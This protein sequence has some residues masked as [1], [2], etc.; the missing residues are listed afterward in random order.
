VSIEYR[1]GIQGDT[2]FTA[3]CLIIE[4]ELVFQNT[5]FVAF[6]NLNLSGVIPLLKKRE[7]EIGRLVNAKVVLELLVAFCVQEA[8]E[9]FLTFI[10]LVIL[11]CAT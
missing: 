1:L 8:S 4:T 6:L 10:Y 9:V 2:D 7:L 11:C 5:D 3:P